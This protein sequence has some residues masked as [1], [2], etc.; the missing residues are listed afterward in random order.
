MVLACESQAI[1]AFCRRAAPLGFRRL[2]VAL[3][4]HGVSTESEASGE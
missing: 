3:D 2:E 4:M 1:E